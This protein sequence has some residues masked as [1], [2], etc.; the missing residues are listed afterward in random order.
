MGF[1]PTAWGQ[2]LASTSSFRSQTTVDLSSIT[3]RA[4]RVL[5]WW[6]SA[7][8]VTSSLYVSL[9]NQE[10]TAIVV[11]GR[12]LPLESL[13]I[14]VCTWKCSPE[15]FDQPTM[16]RFYCA[17]EI[18]LASS[19]LG[20]INLPE[21]EPLP[22]SDDTMPFVFVGD[23]AF[24]LRPYLMRPWPGRMLT[25]EKRKVYNYRLSRARRVV[26]NTFG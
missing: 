7:I 22:G 15:Y 2:S 13:F 16:L 5:Y 9:A 17:I 10:A 26:E 23:E 25:D 8:V 19:V 20:R 24:P 12:T 14:T 1:A 6:L 3:T 11:F 4:Q 18:K 21:D